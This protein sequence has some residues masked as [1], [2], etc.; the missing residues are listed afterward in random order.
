MIILLFYKFLDCALKWMPETNQK[1]FFKD[2]QQGDR[3]WWMW[4]NKVRETGP[5]ARSGQ[6]DTT[7]SV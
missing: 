4:E 5:A 7:N 6:G 2:Q 3:K 1:E